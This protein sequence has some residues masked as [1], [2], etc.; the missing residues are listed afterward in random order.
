MSSSPN[1][2]AYSAEL[3][4]FSRL[5]SAGRGV[6]SRMLNRILEWIYGNERRRAQALL[7]QAE[8]RL[9]RV[10]ADGQQVTDLGARADALP[11]SDEFAKMIERALRGQA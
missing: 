6:T 5:S 11:A 7:S 10:R 4:I 9:A 8:R 1:F 3:S 2:S